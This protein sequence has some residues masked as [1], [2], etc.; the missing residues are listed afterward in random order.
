M[1]EYSAKFCALVAKLRDW[2]ESMK[3]DY[4][5]DGLNVDIMTKVLEL[6]NPDTLVGW[7]QLAIE[8]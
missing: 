3:M 8:V 7:I 5:R 4:Y 1:K 2:P 6:D